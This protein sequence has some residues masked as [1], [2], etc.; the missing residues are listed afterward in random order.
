MHEF[1]CTGA[2]ISSFTTSTITISPTPFTTTQPPNPK[3]HLHHPSRPEMNPTVEAWDMHCGKQHVL[4]KH[5]R[6][7]TCMACEESFLCTGSKDGTVSEWVGGWVSGWVVLV[8][9]VDECVG[10]VARDE[11]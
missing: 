7:I 10:L 6:A 11:S 9:L 1:M 3:V 5:A 8:F 2:Y 4:G